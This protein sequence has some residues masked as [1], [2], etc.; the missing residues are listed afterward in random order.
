MKEMDTTQSFIICI[1]GTHHVLKCHVTSCSIKN[2]SKKEIG[3]RHGKTTP[4]SFSLDRYFQ[5]DGASYL[6]GSPPTG[7]L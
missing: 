1:V 6:K 4:T 5:G 3:F 2:P 7:C